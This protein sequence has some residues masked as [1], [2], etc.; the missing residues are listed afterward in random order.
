[1]ISYSEEKRE[2][3]KQEDSLG[4]R[5]RK[6]HERTAAPQGVDASVD[7]INET[8]PVFQTLAKERGGG[9]AAFQ[10]HFSASGNRDGL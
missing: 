5:P 9:P 10:S 3:I 1:M 8:K 6:E 7:A 2:G 4:T